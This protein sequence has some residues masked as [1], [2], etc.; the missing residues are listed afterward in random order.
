MAGPQGRPGG[1][2]GVGKP[3]TP[4]GSRAFR[5]L[6]K[7]ADS[8]RPAASS[9]PRGRGSSGA[10]AAR[11]EYVSRRKV[12]AI[13]AHLRSFLYAPRIPTPAAQQPP[14]CFIGGSAAAHE[15]ARATRAGEV[16]RA[17]ARG[18]EYLYGLF[19]P[20]MNRKVLTTPVGTRDKALRAR[21][22][23]NDAPLDARTHRARASCVCA[24]R[25]CY[26]CRTTPGPGSQ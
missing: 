26:S 5:H 15:L 18:T 11:V 1:T 23:R 21:R 6:P 12:R 8:W 14:C 16:P 25:T 3:A 10:D 7:R 19:L 24:P 13:G 20:H 2:V 4:L 9:P 22:G 17:H